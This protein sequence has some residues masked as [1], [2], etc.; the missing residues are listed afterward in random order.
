MAEDTEDTGHVEPVA[1]KPE[2]SQQAEQRAH[3]A[4]RDL[5]TEGY[6]FLSAL[7]DVWKARERERVAQWREDNYLPPLPPEEDHP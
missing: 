1:S 6:N 5:I 7:G 4:F 2:T 3:R